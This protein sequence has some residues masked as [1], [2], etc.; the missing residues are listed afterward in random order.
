[1]GDGLGLVLIGTLMRVKST[2]PSYFRRVESGSL[3]RRKNYSNASRRPLIKA[4]KLKTWMIL[5]TDMR[6]WN[7]R[8]VR[9]TEPIIAFSGD[10]RS[11]RD[12]NAVYRTYLI[13]ID[14]L[15]DS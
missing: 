7:V 12:S 3:R 11:A 14:F 9:R 8:G 6:A 10:P 1:M 2:V 5:E 4:I 13:T 15:E